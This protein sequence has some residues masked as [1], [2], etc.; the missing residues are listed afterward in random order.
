MY[1]CLS[2]QLPD[3][4][5]RSRRCQTTT[6]E[7]TIA[8]EITHLRWQNLRHGPE[9]DARVLA[10]LRGAQ[11]PKRGSKL[12]AS[13]FEQSLWEILGSSYRGSEIFHRLFYFELD[14]VKASISAS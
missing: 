3:I 5:S 9:F 12:N 7:G 2:L 10:L 6:L 4:S 14:A 13:Q 8:H 11:F 1:E